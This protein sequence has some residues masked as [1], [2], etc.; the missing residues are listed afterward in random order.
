MRS[1]KAA[2][3]AVVLW[4]SGA[5]AQQYVISSYAGGAPPVAAPVQGTSV[6][7]GEAISV[8]TDEKG[9][10]YF[11]SPDLNSVFKLDPSGV[12]TR[13]AGSSKYGYS[14]DGGPATEARMN[15]YFGNAEA[16]SSGLVVDSAGNLFVADTSNHCVRRVSPSGIITTVA[17]TGVAGFSGDGGAAVDAKLAYPWGVAV[18]PAG[19]LFILDTFN[20]RVRKVSTSGIITTLA[21]VTGW[22][23]AVDSESNVFVTTPGS[24]IRR[25][26]G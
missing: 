2:L 20:S 14:G 8:A 9:N 4:C 5:A 11:A 19:N 18:D 21:I 13:I 15:L 3:A 24:A 6:S 7:I 12:L 25:V 26:S 1:I 10:I 16:L 17:G 22:A 23:L